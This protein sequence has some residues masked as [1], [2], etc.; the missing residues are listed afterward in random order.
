M[1][2]IGVLLEDSGLVSI[3]WSVARYVA[4]IKELLDYGI[5]VRNLTRSIVVR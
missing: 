1:A 3:G 4:R 2:R 5:V